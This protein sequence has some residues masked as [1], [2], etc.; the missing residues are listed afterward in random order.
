[1]IRKSLLVLSCFFALAASAQFTITRS[2]KSISG[3]I[4]RIEGT[5]V[6]LLDD[7]LVIDVAEDADITSDAG[8]GSLATLQP[9]MRI[10]AGVVPWWDGSLRAMSIHVESDHDASLYAIID[11]VDFANSTFLIAGQTV[12][13]TE[14]TEVRRVSLGMA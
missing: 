14:A 10:K 7:R 13:F 11:R 2:N 4:S 5:R 6:Y 3:T 1:M 8:F 9:G 12:R